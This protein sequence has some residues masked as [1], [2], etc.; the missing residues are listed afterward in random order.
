MASPELFVITEF[1][2]PMFFN[3][4]SKIK[5][6]F[7]DLYNN[8]VYNDARKSLTLKGEVQVY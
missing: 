1:D 7:E 8:I 2:C 4:V 5:L 3:A 6:I